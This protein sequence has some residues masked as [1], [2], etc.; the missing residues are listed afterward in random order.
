[1]K[2]IRT[3]VVVHRLGTWTVEDKS[4]TSLQDEYILITQK[5]GVARDNPFPIARF[6]S[7]HEQRVARS[8]NQPLSRDTF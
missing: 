2:I 1:M 7:L 3:P 6:P 8:Q 4:V 5:I